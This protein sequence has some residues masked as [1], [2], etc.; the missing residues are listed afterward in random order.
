MT[1]ITDNEKRERLGAFYT[2]SQLALWV[3]SE[4]LS[5][6]VGGKTVV[7]CDPAC[8]D[9]ELLFALKSQI[10]SITGLGMDVDADAIKE[11]KARCGRAIRFLVGNSVIPSTRDSLESSW[12]KILGSIKPNIFIMNPPWGIDFRKSRSILES[13]GYSLANGQFDSYEIFC[14]AVIR[15]AKP[16]A[17]LAFILP[18]SIF[19]P[20]KLNFRHYLLQT[21]KLHLLARLGE[22]FFDGVYRSTSV[23]IAQK[24]VASDEHEVKCLRLTPA[25]RGGIL[26]GKL[27][28]AKI[29]RDQCHRVRQSRFSADR[30]KRFD[31]DLRENEEI[32]ISKFQVHEPTWSDWLKSARGVEISKTGRV[33]ICPSCEHANPYPRQGLTKTCSFCSHVFD[34]ESEN[35]RSIIF[36]SEDRPSNSR[37]IIVGEDVDRYQIGSSRFISE[38]VPGIDYKPRLR[39]VTPRILVRKTGLGIKAALDL[40]GDYT[41]QVV[42]MYY[43][44]DQTVPDFFLYY[45]LGVLCS[46]VALSYF[47]RTHGEVEWKSHPYVTQKIL[48][49][50]PIPVFTQ[51]SKTE[52][53]ARAIA[54]AVKVF[55]EMDKKD[56]TRDI[57]VDCLV[58]GIY[59]LS[60]AEC[61][62]VVNVLRE[63]QSLEPIRTLRLDAYELL[64]PHHVK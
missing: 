18:D 53:Q 64:L 49:S 60:R 14:E 27:Q 55:C 50:I 34:A 57:F 15:I 11:A 19:Y 26:N 32:T 25:D 62:W 43:R 52:K 31:L 59:N 56:Q 23:L 58:A 35:T 45:V 2:P 4:A 42:F 17:I 41:N 33:A 38:N 29:A 47:L 3:A 20:E 5:Y 22:G 7:S 36:S 39:G 6:T 28:L 1:P 30:E 40:S 51:G 24:G 37:R 10:P 54:D 21:C 63:A 13:L 46:R 48:N 9:G 12:K 44:K 61:R 8:G 16:G